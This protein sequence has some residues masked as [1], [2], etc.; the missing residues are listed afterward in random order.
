MGMYD[1]I[2]IPKLYCYHCAAA[3]VDRFWQSKS[4]ECVLIDL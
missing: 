4:G 2:R 1:E 3:L